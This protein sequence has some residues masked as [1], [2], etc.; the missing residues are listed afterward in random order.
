MVVMVMM[1]TES[2]K[3]TKKT[4]RKEIRWAEENGKSV[5]LQGIY[6][7]YLLISISLHSTRTSAPEIARE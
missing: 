5:S 2:R 3:K 1:S 4:G 7:I 6:R